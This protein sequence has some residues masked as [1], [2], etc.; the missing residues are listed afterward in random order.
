MKTLTFLYDLTIK[1][2]LNP[3]FFYLEH[4]KIVNIVFLL[5]LIL[6]YGKKF[7]YISNLSFHYIITLYYASNSGEQLLFW[8]G[9][10]GTTSGT[11]LGI[12]LTKIFLK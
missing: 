1:S 9:L 5:L 11:V 12:V 7:L 3:V 6:L 4:K 8:G 2:L 10:I